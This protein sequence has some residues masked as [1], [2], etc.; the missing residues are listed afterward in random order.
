MKKSGLKLLAEKIETKEEHKKYL[1]MG[2]DL[3]QGFHLNRPEII[4][5]DSYKDIPQFVIFK[6]NTTNKK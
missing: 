2:F 3:F 6:Y 5:I 1:D 4:E